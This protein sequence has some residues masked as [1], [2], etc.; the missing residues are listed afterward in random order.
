MKNLP[1]FAVNRP[2]TIM[3]ISIGMIGFGL[4]GL[5]KLRLNLYPEVYF[6]TVTVYSTYEGVATED[7]ETL[8]TRQIEE[9]VGSISGVRRIRSLSSQGAS[10]VKLNFNW[11]TDLFI[12]E[13]EVR[14]RLDMIRR[15][16]PDDVDQP[17]VLSY[18]PKIGRAH[19]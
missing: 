17:I 14:K 15:S 11:G 7:I 8:M 3:M 19:V 4:Y 10:V 2:I 5:C 6:P 16:L 1:K 18:D 12:A 9:Q 13:T